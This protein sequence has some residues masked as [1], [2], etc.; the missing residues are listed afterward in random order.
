MN[1]EKKPRKIKPYTRKWDNL[2]N[3]LARSV[4]NIN[5]CRHCGRPVLEGY[6]CGYCG[7]VTP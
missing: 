2:A 6:C 5:A 3:S 1:P 4:H 7:S